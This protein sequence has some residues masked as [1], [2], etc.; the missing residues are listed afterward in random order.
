MFVRVRSRP[1]HRRPSGGGARLPSR[2]Q[3][4]V[5]KRC[6]DAADLGQRREPLRRRRVE[7]HR[8]RYPRRCLARERRRGGDGGGGAPELGIP[9]EVA[10]RR[11][12]TAA[13]VSSPCASFGLRVAGQAG[14]AATLPSGGGT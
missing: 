2:A 13:R 6:G 5:R 3:S 7:E 10:E 14:A 1:R 9:G 4:D 8:G 12:R 11:A